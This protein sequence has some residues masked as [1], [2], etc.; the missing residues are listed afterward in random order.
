MLTHW[1]YCSLALNH[2]Y[3]LAGSVGTT[4]LV[5]MKTSW[6]ENDLPITGLCVYV[7]GEFP[8]N[9]KWCTPLMSPFTPT[10]TSVSVTP[11][12]WFY[13]SHRN[14]KWNT[15]ILNWG[16]RISWWR[17]QMETFSALLA[18][19][20]AINRALMFSFICAW[21]KGWINNRE[22]GNLRRHRAHYD[23]T[24]KWKLYWYRPI[25]ASNNAV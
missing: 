17:H 21:I 2:R 3:F 24:V 8:A 19:C 1:R 20:A 13:N 18:I 16:S 11:L 22:A 7:Y 4:I 14:P 9:N 25:P 5:N 23:V 15:V 10:R 6:H 12:Y